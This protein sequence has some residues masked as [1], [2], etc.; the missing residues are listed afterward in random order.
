L[1]KQLEAFKETWESFNPHQKNAFVKA[2]KHEIAEI[3]EGLEFE[4]EV[5]PQ[6]ED[7]TDD[8]PALS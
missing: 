6:K 2:N 7:E 4:K 3:L 1:K 8:Q 5:A